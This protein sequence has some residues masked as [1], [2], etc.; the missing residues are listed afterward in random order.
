MG[1]TYVVGVQSSGD[2]CEYGSEDSY[3]RLGGL[4]YDWIRANLESVSARV[5]IPE[6]QC[7]VWFDP[8]GDGTEWAKMIKEFDLNNDRRISEREFRELYEDFDCS[9]EGALNMFDRLDEDGDSELNDAEMRD[10]W[11]Y[12]AGAKCERF[13]EEEESEDEPEWSSNSDASVCCDSCDRDDDTCWSQCVTCED[14]TWSQSSE[15]SDESVCCDACD[16]DD[17][18]CWSECVTCSDRGNTDS[19]ESV[20]CDSCDSDDDTC[21]SR[22]I[23]C[24]PW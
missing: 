23:T 19:D 13:G 5:S 21:F 11:V 8:S 4:A 6:D 10:A 20:C 1:Q 22:C 12:F 14:L 2:C 7:S 15:S 3:A 24:D 9:K 16:R 17:D 18:T